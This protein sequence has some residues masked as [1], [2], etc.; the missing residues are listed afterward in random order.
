MPARVREDVSWTWLKCLTIGGRRAA[1][2]E[3][4]RYWSLKY[5]KGEEEMYAAL[6]LFTLGPG[7]REIADKSGEKFGPML[8]GMKG[9]KSMTMF[10]DHDTGEYGGLTIWETKE[11]AEAALAATEGPMQEA[12]GD[13]L[14]GPPTRKVFELWEPK[15]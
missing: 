9:F 12:L 15:A 2:G 3:D 10:G 11:D 14:K 4:A 6:T 1:H 13:L 5:T 8:Q 7:T